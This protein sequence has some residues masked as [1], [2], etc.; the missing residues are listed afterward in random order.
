MYISESLMNQMFDFLTIHEYDVWSMKKSTN[1]F[2]VMPACKMVQL[3]LDK[4][5]FSQVGTAQVIP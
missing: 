3:P 5:D 4:D 1:T 2:F